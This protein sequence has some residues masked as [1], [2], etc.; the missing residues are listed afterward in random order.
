[1]LCRYSTQGE[2]LS[3]H[4]CEHTPGSQQISHV[5]NTFT[6]PI[7]KQTEL[8]QCFPFQLAETLYRVRDSI[9][10][11]CVP[12]TLKGSHTFFTK[13]SLHGAVVLCLWTPAPRFTEWNAVSI[14]VPR[15]TVERTDDLASLV[16]VQV[17]S[18]QYSA[19]QGCAVQ[20]SSS[21][22]G[23]L[24]FLW[25]SSVSQLYYSSH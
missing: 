23:F 11:D 16:P 15:W 24:V 1:M 14:R 7:T 3:L 9:R 21:S 4:H 12:V 25:A 17:Q 22:P 10:S 6:V 13:G 20:S 2:S 8:H 5:I 18:S 19:G